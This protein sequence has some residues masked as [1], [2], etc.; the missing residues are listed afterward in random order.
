VQTPLWPKQVGIEEEKAEVMVVVALRCRAVAMA[1]GVSSIRR[2]RSVLLVGWL[3][4]FRYTDIRRRER[5]LPRFCRDYATYHPLLRHYST[6]FMPLFHTVCHCSSAFYRLSAGFRAMEDRT[7]TDAILPLS[8]TSAICLPVFTH[9]SA[10]VTQFCHISA[11]VCRSIGAKPGPLWT[12]AAAPYL[13]RAVARPAASHR[14]AFSEPVGRTSTVLLR[15]YL[16]NHTTQRP[17]HTVTWSSL[18]VF[19]ASLLARAKKARTMTVCNQ[20]GG[21]NIEADPASGASI[22]VACGNVRS[23]ALNRPRV[24]TELTALH[25]CLLV[26]HYGRSS[27][28]TRS[29]PRSR[30][31]RRRRARRFCRASSFL[32]RPVLPEVSTWLGRSIDAG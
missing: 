2:L 11:S 7:V 6:I 24:A 5:I 29:C 15:V 19:G 14:A 32:P 3:A 23:L 28:R 13:D 18:V 1:L 16:P 31:P 10:D 25:A 27:K 4:L 21:S 17:D 26:N 22:C 20:C 12:T 9:H 30:S 8:P